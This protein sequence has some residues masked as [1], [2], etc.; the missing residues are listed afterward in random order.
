MEITFNFLGKRLEKRRYIPVSH[1]PDCIGIV[2][3]QTADVVQFAI[4]E[5]ALNSPQAHG[6]QWA[7]GE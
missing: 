5:T 4:Q 7:C 6:S 1:S 2:F 3:Q